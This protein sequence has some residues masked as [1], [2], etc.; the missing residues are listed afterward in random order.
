LIR[1]LALQEA[2]RFRAD[3]RADDVDVGGREAVHDAPELA[4]ADALRSVDDVVEV[5][6]RAAEA[7]GGLCD[8]AAAQ[9]QRQL[10]MGSQGRT[11]G[12]LGGAALVSVSR[13]TG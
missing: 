9:F 10:D 4:D 2:A 13:R 7:L 11:A 1:S 8:A 12:L 6:L 3:E 5:R